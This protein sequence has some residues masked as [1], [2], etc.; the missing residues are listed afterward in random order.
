MIDDCNFNNKFEIKYINNELYIYYYDAISNFTSDNIKLKKD[1]L[2]ILIKGNNLIISTMF[3]EYLII[4]GT[5]KLI[6]FKYE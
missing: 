4:S 2:I 3:K 1:N 5:I 6:E